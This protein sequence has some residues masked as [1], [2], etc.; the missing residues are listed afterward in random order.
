[1]LCWGFNGAGQ[2]GD[3]TM[4]IRTLPVYVLDIYN[5]V[6]QVTAGDSHTCGRTFAGGVKCWGDNT[7]GELGDGTTYRSL[8]PVNT[9]GLGGTA[10]YISAGYFHTC[11]V[12]ADYSVQCW[13]NNQAGQLGDGTTFM[14]INPTYVSGLSAPIGVLGSGS[15]TTC[16]VSIYGNAQCW[17]SH[18]NGQA[19]DGSIPWVLTPS[20]VSGLIMPHFSINYS[21]GQPGSFFTISGEDLP[22]NAAVNVKANNVFLTPSTMTDPDGKLV[23]LLDTSLADPGSYVITVIVN[24]PYNLS[25]KLDETAPLRAQEGSG[26]IYQIPGGIGMTLSLYLPFNFR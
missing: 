2:L 7:Y 16:A 18:A 19:G 3:G 8:T 20:E 25:F 26:V 9:N 17:G 5:E 24:K 12:L 13:G 22:S 23:I 14:R 11:A 10:I 15:N 6:A 1:V 4:E 21:N